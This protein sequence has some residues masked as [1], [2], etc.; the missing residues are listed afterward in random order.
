MIIIAHYT[1][2]KQA[3]SSIIYDL[4]FLPE[5]FRSMHAGTARL[6]ASAML[7]PACHFRLTAV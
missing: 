5:N 6:A 4:W 1:A 7:I 3:E 2:K